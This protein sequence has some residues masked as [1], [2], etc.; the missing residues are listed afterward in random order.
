MKM[1]FAMWLLCG[2]IGGLSAGCSQQARPVPPI[3]S[4]APSLAV[5]PASALSVV[6]KAGEVQINYHVPS[7]PALEPGEWPALV[8]FLSQEGETRLDQRIVEAKERRAGMLGSST[9]YRDGSSVFFYQI[10]TADESGLAGYR[11][12]IYDPERQEIRPDVML[13]IIVDDA[14]ASSSAASSFTTSEASIKLD[15]KWLGQ[16]AQTSAA[17]VGFKTK[18]SDV[19]WRIFQRFLTPVLSTQL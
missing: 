17:L 19:G 14:S 6:R 13:K 9:T 4:S 7:F 5:T 2:L 15:W 3:T 10:A 1:C 12:D 18:K 16:R 8:V 11:F